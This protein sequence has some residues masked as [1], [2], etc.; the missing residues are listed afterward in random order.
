MH[1]GCLGVMKKMMV[2]FWLE[3]NLATKLSQNK[4]CQLSQRLLE[5]QSQIPIDFQRTTRSIADI[6]KW[7]ATEYR[8]YLL[9]VGPVVSQQ[10]LEKRYYNHFLL[11]HTACRILSSDNFC[12]K[13]N[14]QAKVYLNN[15]VML[16]KQYYNTQSL[17]INIHSHL[18]DDVK[19]MKYSL[20]NYTTFPFENLLGKMKKL[21]RSGNRRAHLCR[22]LHESFYAESDKVMLPQAVII[23]K[24]GLPEQTNSCQKNQ[25]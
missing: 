17:I 10:V 9:Y 4:K 8:L 14:F 15:F 7:K 24:T 22:R 19:N 3:G 18:A 25:V 12:L 6:S 16:T 13:Y 20:S 23:L 21:L 2:D 1:Q 5:L 11:L